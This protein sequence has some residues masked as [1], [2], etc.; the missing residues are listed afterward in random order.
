MKKRLFFIGLII[1]VIIGAPV[2]FT[3]TCSSINYGIKY[4]LPALISY[5]TQIIGSLATFIA[6]FVAL[7][8]KEIRA[9]I[10][11][12]HCC[13]SLVDEG[14]TENLGATKDALNPM[15]QSYDCTLL[16]KNDGSKE[17][18]ELQIF[19]KE[20]H[21]KS[22]SNSKK[23]KPLHKFENKR[24]YW[25]IPE[26][27]TT[28]LLLKDKKT[29]PLFKIYPEDSCQTPDRSAYSSL[30]MRI[31]GCTLDE[32][33]SKNGVWRTVYQIQ[34]KERVL[35]TFECIIEWDGKWFNRISEMADC[36]TAKINRI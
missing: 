10:F 35:E 25:N 5:T 21:Y 36:V 9:F 8:G 15:A 27:L 1:I 31:I 2:Y 28:Q 14:F 23:Y 17:I 6:V 29:M 33:C 16:I 13:I 20:V 11:N 26:N 3:W 34:S 7:F 24:L 30:R 32:K 19:L 22:S 4:G 18:S 12:E